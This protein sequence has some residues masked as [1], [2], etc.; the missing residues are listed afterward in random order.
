M[1]VV[2]NQSINKIFS[3]T[4]N[5]MKLFLDP[6]I[7]SVH[8]FPALGNDK[9]PS[10]LSIDRE[11]NQLRPIFILS[12]VTSANGTCWI[13]QGNTKI[14]CSIK[15]P[16]CLSKR[17]QDPDQATIKVNVQ[18]F[19]NLYEKNENYYYQHLIPMMI[20]RAI[21]PVLS[22]ECYP[23]SMI[24]INITILENDGNILSACITAVSN[25]L[26]H[27]GIDIKDLVI[28]CSCIQIHLSNDETAWILDGTKDDEMNAIATLYLSYAPNLK[29]ITW[30]DWHCTNSALDI[31]SSD[32]KHA[33]DTCI[34]ACCM[35]GDW[36]KQALLSNKKD[37]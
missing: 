27:I 33:I 35:I 23:G 6:P 4:Y 1:N 26:A 11:Y 16:Y 29:Q 24:E 17:Q 10:S 34:T 8:P 36:S 3:Y 5:L 25:A 2:A 37:A 15:R 19:A 31:T 30:I 22:L 12:G 9:Y 14:F 32:M 18:P 20:K 28:G 13:E 7:K 21:S